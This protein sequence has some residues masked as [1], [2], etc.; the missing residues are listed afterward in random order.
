MLAARQQ[1]SFGGYKQVVERLLDENMGPMPLHVYMFGAEYSP[2]D[3]AQ[4]VCSPGEWQA[5]TSFT[6]HPFGEAFDLE[7]ADNRLH[8]QFLNL[9]LDTMMT[10]IKRSLLDRHPVCWE[11]DISERGF[12]WP[13][14]M[15]DLSLP[16]SRC[17]QQKR[18]LM[19]ERRLTTDDHCM[20]L[21]GLV[22]RRSD[23]TLFFVAKNSWG[24][25]NRHHGFM[26]LSEKYVR[27]KTVGVCLKA[28]PFKGK[29]K[30]EK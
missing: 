2:V 29:V 22:R 11:G 3:F 7:V 9:P 30:R 17:T 21:I 24:S 26:L 1:P 5:V 20:A 23:G 18:Q 19:F 14:G 6:H 4:S 13:D 25:S 27:M 8:E 10:M 16:M 28:L 15:A 12:S